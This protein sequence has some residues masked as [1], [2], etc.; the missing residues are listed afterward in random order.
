MPRWGMVIDL[1][2]CTACQACVVACQAENNVPCVEP[3]Q[4]AKGRIISWLSVLPDLKGQYPNVLM[5]LMPLPCLHCDEPPCIRVCPVGATGITPE[6][7][8]RQT[9]P[10][11]I[12]CRYCTNAC[13][14]TRRSFNWRLPDFPGELVQALNPDVSVR[15]KGVVEKCTLCHH[16]LL[17]AREQARAEDRPLAVGDYVP[18]CVEICPAEAMYFGDLEDPNSKVSELA[19]SARAFRYL[20]ELGTEPKVVFLSEGE[21]AGGEQT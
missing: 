15:P 9:F 20:E 18:A 11:C 7:I 19:E 4:A 14:Y 5:R 3:E 13:P 16:R 21:W 8:V 1:A 12:G 2:K 10:R 6:G 17:R